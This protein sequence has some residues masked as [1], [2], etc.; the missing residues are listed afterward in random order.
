MA[1]NN[2]FNRFFPSKKKTKDGDYQEHQAI[3]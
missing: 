1:I 2:I 3:H